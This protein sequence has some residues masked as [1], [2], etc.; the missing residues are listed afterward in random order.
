IPAEGGIDL[1]LIVGNPVGVAG[2]AHAQVVAGDEPGDAEI[3]AALIHSDGGVGAAIHARVIVDLDRGTRGCAVIVGSSQVEVG[4]AAARRGGT[5]ID[6]IGPAAHANVVGTVPGQVGFGV[7]AGRPGWNGRGAADVRR[8]DGEL[9]AEPPAQAAG[10]L[11][12]VD[13]R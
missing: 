10:I 9:G 4:G 5:G 1:G 6:E 12:G 3:A 8:G 7:D 2:A 11:V 13:G